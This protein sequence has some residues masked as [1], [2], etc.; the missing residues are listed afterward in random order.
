MRASTIKLIC[1]LVLMLGAFWAK[2]QVKFTAS[3]NRTTVGRNEQFQVEFELNAR[4]SGFS[5]PDF[6]NFRVVQGP[7][8]GQSTQ[9]I[10]FKRSESLTFSYVLRAKN[11]GTFTI[12]PASIEVDGKTYSSEPLTIKVSQESP[13]ANDP[14]DPYSIAARSAFIKVIPSKT[15]LYQ[16]EP[17]VAS[18]KLFL[19][20]NV[21][22]PQIESEPD[23]TGFYRENVEVKRIST[24]PEMYQGERY[25]AGVIRQMVLIPQ[26]SGS[27]RPGLVEIQLPTAVPTNQRDF[28]NRPVSR[29]INQTSTDNFPTVRVKPLPKEG[30]PSDFDGAVGDYEFKVSLSRNE[31]DASE[32]VTLVV[33]LKGKGNIKLVDAPEP[34]IPN[35]FEAYDP[36]YKENIRING[37][38]MSGTK[39]YKYLLIPRY[40]GTYKIPPLSFS[41]F[42]PDR[43]RYETITTEELEIKVTGG[44]A[45]PATANGGAGNTETEKV[46]FIG[47][48]IL[49]IKTD[50]GNLSKKGQSYLGSAVFYTVLGGSGVAFA[51][52]L[53]FFFLVT[54]RQKDYRKERSQ[55]ASKLARKHL[56]QAKKE[57]GQNNKEAFYLALTNALWGYFSDKF[58]IPNSQLS[59]EM[60][61]EKLAAN[62]VSSETTQQ[63]MEIMNRAEMARFTSTAD[64]SPQRDYDDTALLITQIEREV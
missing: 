7:M 35:A 18:Y 45:Q 9:I 4:G 47:K 28:F 51:G 31:I 23:F 6:S 14:N 16:G 32:S 3:S 13:R 49:F 37:G 5:A 19:K 62:G 17:F 20:T 15:N 46:G 33:E 29:T 10:N 25:E 12:G 8:R 41:Y 44:A 22:Q 1:A 59:K 42:D 63:V 26:R 21:G 40:G 58:S 2:A 43:E 27:I 54:N 38:G 60:I 11:T 50:P 55:K 24:S 48:D 39:T 57:L 64:F 53:L 36:E 34:E 56:A 61:E 52:M 30:Q